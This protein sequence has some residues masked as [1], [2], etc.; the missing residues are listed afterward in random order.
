MSTPT[1]EIEANFD[2]FS[3]SWKSELPKS[4]AWLDSHRHTFL[5]SNSRIV[6]MNAWRSNF[7]Q[8]N[9]AQGSLEFFSEA[10]ND[11]LISHV[12][13]RFGSWR[14]ALNSLRSCIEN[15]CYCL[16]YKD[17]PI[18][19]QLWELGKHRPGFSEIH[20]YLQQ[21]P[22]LTSLGN[23]S[24]TG[25]AI[26][27]DEYG[28]LSRAVHASARSFRM[29]PN[30]HEVALWR[31]DAQSLGQWHTRE[32]L[33]LTGLNLLLTTMFRESLSGA[34][35]RS[36][37]TALALVIPASS[38]KKVKDQLGITI[39][40]VRVFFAVAPTFQII[41]PNYFGGIGTHS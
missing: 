18:E 28:T 36:L 14:S 16:Y 9:I 11:T 1:A 5:Q 24:V 21:H 7:L 35:Q 6:S 26:I 40:S 27:K 17:H 38:R 39:P 34:Q 20:T 13:A 23:A 10:L 31:P 25:L 30:V 32:R 37:R 19:L 2:V 12:F 22:K 29:S 3:T 33:N 41:L 8:N 4:I 15:T